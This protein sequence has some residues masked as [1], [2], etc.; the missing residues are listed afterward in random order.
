MRYLKLAL[1]PRQM[2][3]NMCRNRRAL[4]LPSLARLDREATPKIVLS[5]FRVLA[6]LEH[7]LALTPVRVFT[8]KLVGLGELV[9]LPRPGVVEVELVVINSEDADL[10][11]CLSDKIV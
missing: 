5:G 10:V 6:E 3:F 11:L 1:S 8:P 2:S 4:L 9:P 7:D